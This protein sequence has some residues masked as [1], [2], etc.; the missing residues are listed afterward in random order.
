MMGATRW[1]AVAAVVVGAFF[2]ASRLHDAAPWVLRVAL[3]VGP[4]AFGA[5]LGRLS[6][7]PARYYLSWAIPMAVVMLLANFA[8]PSLGRYLVWTGAYGLFLLLLFSTRANRWWV[9][10][11]DRIVP[12]GDS[13]RR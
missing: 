2:A 11:V 7:S 4:P 8:I 10:L 1:A 13:S 5:I 9:Q 3:A 12:P 6:G